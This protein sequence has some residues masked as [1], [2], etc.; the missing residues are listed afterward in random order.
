MLPEKTGGCTV[1]LCY[2]KCSFL[3][4][5]KSIFSITVHE[6]GSFIKNKKK[7]APWAACAC[8]IIHCVSPGILQESRQDHIFL[9]LIKLVKNDQYVIGK[10]KILDVDK[11]LAVLRIRSNSEILPCFS[12]FLINGNAPQP[13]F[14]HENR[15]RRSN[16]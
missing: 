11:K 5:R 8:P 2:G 3:Q 12:P 6:W 1:V 16:P 7:A 15:Y 9:L 4:G 14:F 10:P 13:S